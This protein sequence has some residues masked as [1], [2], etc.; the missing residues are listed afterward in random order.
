VWRFILALYH[1]SDPILKATRGSTKRFFKSNGKYPS[2]RT[3]TLLYKLSI[4][5]YIIGLESIDNL[6]NLFVDS[7]VASHIGSEMSLVQC[8]DE[9][10]H[11]FCYSKC[12]ITDKEECLGNDDDDLYLTDEIES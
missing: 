2:L 7:L 1:I 9:A 6:K 10:P 5:S 3:E 11:F 8:K 12:Q 4:L